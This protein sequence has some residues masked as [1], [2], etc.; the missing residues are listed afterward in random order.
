MAK[1]YAQSESPISAVP[2]DLVIWGPGD[3]RPSCRLQ[4]GIPAA[5]TWP[6]Q[7]P[8][9]PPPGTW[10]WRGR[11]VSYRADRRTAVGLGEQAATSIRP[12]IRF[13]AGKSC[14]AGRRN[15][16]GSYVAIPTSRWRHLKEIK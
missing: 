4:D 10:G 15:R 12:S 8:S 6:E 16:V 5:G 3:P 9:E 11:A 13:Q 1:Y 2:G 14:T 7:P